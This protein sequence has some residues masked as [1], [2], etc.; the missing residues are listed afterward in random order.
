MNRFYLILAV[1]LVKTLFINALW[2]LGISGIICL[3]RM[4]FTRV[5]WGNFFGGAAG[6]FA[7]FFILGAYD[8]IRTLI[9]M[10][11]DPLFR[12]M[13]IATG[14]SWRDYLRDKRNGRYK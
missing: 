4:L 8:V 6:I 10:K 3:G 9:L 11:K 13:N 7:L 5:S 12:D 14:I 1:G 2:S